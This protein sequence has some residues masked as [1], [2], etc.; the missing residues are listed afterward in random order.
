MFS[1]IKNLCCYICI[2]KNSDRQ[3]EIIY[4]EIVTVEEDI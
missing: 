3:V 2:K 1:W 4:K